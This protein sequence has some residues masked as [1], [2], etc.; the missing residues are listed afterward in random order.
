MNWFALYKS[1][2]V[3]TPIRWLGTLLLLLILVGYFLRWPAPIEATLTLLFGF[4][5]GWLFARE[6]HVQTQNKKSRTPQEIEKETLED[7][8]SVLDMPSIAV[9]PSRYVVA[10]NPL[11]YSLFPSLALGHPLALVSRNPELHQAIERVLKNNVSDTCEM[12]ERYQGGRSLVV[13]VTPLL[14]VSTLILQFRDKSGE[15]LLSQMQS[16]FIANASHE[17]RTPLASIKG[18]IETLQ[19]SARTDETARVRFL[20]IMDEQAARMN[21]IL[22]DLLSLSRI[23]MRAHLHPNTSVNIIEIIQKVLSSLELLA[24]QA[25]M[26]LK[27][28]PPHISQLVIGDRDELEQVVQ[29]L[30]HNAIKYGTAGG[31]VE[32]S[33]ERKKSN[34]G[35]KSVLELS[36]K[37]DGP[38]IPPEHLPRL[39][40]RFY[41]VDS[42]RS[43]EQGG[44]GLGLSIVKHILKR[45][46]TDLSIRSELGK[47]SIFSTTLEEAA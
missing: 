9:T 11:A 31:T 17:L 7:L 27:F 33:L 43:R 37:D 16:D 35:T 8:V 29:N 25:K 47:G 38:G 19:G 2:Q 28:Q 14:K 1:L 13:S 20:S 42:A 41:R 44:T 15:I 10:F 18:F 32:V 3:S 34:D 36:V 21:R 46:K 45:H 4:L 5:I 23:E 26:K 39:T 12:T 24:Q 6:P 40:E 30:V 22:D